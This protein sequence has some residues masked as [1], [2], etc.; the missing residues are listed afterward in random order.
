[1]ALEERYPFTADT[2]ASI[3]TSGLLG[4]QYVGLENGGEPEN[5]QDGDSI[6]LTSS[7][8]VLESLIGEFMYDKMAEGAGGN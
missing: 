2:S 3:L 8:L 5:L 7:A 1:M 6:F 4:E